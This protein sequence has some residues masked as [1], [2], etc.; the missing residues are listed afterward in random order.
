MAA[1]EHLSPSSN[2]EIVWK[3]LGVMKLLEV[4]VTPE[5]MNFAFAYFLALL[6]WPEKSLGEGL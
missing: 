3:G 6:T 4:E 2:F 5:I 1:H